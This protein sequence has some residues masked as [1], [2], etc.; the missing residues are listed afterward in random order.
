M[1]GTSY[2][3]NGIACRHKLRTREANVG[4]VASVRPMQSDQFQLHAEIEERHWW[5]VARRRIMRRLVRSIVP[6]S[7]EATIVDVGCGTGA[8]IAALSDEYHC[9][10]I[11]T[12][13]EAIHR[14]RARF[15]G[16]R[17]LVGQA[18][19]ALGE[20]A[21][22][23]KL[24][25]LMDVLEHCADDAATF[26][27]LLA[28]AAPGAHFLITVPADPALWSQ[29]DE[30][31]GHYRRYQ[32]ARFERVWT[33]LPVATRLISYFNSRMYP[34]VRMVRTWNRV[35]GRAS[36]RAGTDFW[37]PP[38]PLNRLLEATFAAEGR[39][40]DKVLRGRRNRGYRAGASLLAL[41][42][43]EAGPVVT[44]GGL[45]YGDCDAGRIALASP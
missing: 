12:S 23:V 26:S 20:V 38:A 9:V 30:S 27:D 14:A 17:F 5:F 35:R 16:V 43:R 15:S 44:P 3:W 33:G 24:F 8:N 13:A 21:R 19:D 22:R 42:R 11:D 18:P 40:L 32:R 37:L 31:F 29:H 36:G 41:L 6:P 7:P 2:S 34:L 4:D 25:L 10:G 28:A 1:T 39:V 45:G